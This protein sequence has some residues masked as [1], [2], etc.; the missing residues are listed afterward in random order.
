MPTQA[1]PVGDRGPGGAAIRSSG[2]QAC[3]AAPRD[4]DKAAKTSAYRG[5]SAAEGQW[6][7]SRLRFGKHIIHLGR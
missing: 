4:T 1:S 5:V 2:L 6:W 3:A 7:R